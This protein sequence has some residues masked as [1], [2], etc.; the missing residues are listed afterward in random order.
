MEFRSDFCTV[1][2]SLQN[3][4]LIEDNIFVESATIIEVRQNPS[5]ETRVSSEI[6][7]VTGRPSSDQHHLRS[8]KGGEA[9]VQPRLSCV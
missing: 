9:H 5:H 6:S 8:G 4:V 2:D 3:R 7:M 1:N